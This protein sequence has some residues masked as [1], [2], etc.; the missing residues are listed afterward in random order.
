MKRET[1][2]KSTINDLDNRC[3]IPMYQGGLPHKPYF[4]AINNKDQI[5][6][7]LSKKIVGTHMVRELEVL[8]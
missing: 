6:I 5:I 2:I 1:K 7:G 3:Q 4:I 8:I